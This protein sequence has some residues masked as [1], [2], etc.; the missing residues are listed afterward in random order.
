[1][2]KHNLPFLFTQ[3]IKDLKHKSS[4]LNFHRTS[5]IF[6]IMFIK[7]IPPAKQ[8]QFCYKSDLWVPRREN[9]VQSG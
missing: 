2:V 7:I 1:M 6:L 9:G 3:K 4:F 8:G 5:S